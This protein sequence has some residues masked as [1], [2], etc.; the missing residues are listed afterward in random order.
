LFATGA[1]VSHKDKRLSET[2]RY[3]IPAVTHRVEEEILRSRF[4]TTVGYTPTVVA[5]RAFI[6]AVSGEFAD[7]NHNCWAYVVGPPGSTAQIG[8]SDDGEPHGTA[9]RP[10]LTVVQHSGIG[11]L[12]AV[13]TRYFGGT[14]LGKGGLV[15]AYSGGVQ[16]ALQT[17]PI[18]QHVPKTSYLLV[19]DYA[20][21]TPFQRL[22][23][24][25]EAEIVQSEFAGDVTYQVQL[26]TEQAAAFQQAVVELTNGQ[27]VL[28]EI[29]QEVSQEIVVP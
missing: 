8:T 7:A 12:C 9:G 11:D 28:E 29:S 16:L 17:L 4:I 26:P 19:I 20:A 13:V 15:K 1:N 5:A 18:T 22:C 21:V 2:A 3:A 25:Y 14:L 10:M 23:P 27:V 6:T 24:A